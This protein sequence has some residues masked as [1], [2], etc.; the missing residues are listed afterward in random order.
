MYYLISCESY[1]KQDEEIKKIVKDNNYQI[2]NM[3]KNTLDEVI[4]ELS[5]ISF[6]NSIKYLVIT[7]APFFGVDKLKEE[8][9]KLLIDLLSKKSSDV[10]IFTTLNQVDKRKK[11]TKLIKDLGNLIE[12]PKF[13]KRYL[14]EEVVK[15]LNKYNY[16][17]DFNTSMYI[18]NN[19]FNNLDIIY[20]ELDKVIAYYNKPRTLTICDIRNIISR[21]IDDNN[22]HFVSL[23]IDKNLKEAFIS[24]KDL[25]KLKVEPTVLITLLARE[26]RLMYYVKNLKLNRIDLAKTLS[27]VDWQLDKLYNNSLKYTNKELLNNILNLSKLDIGIKKGL[28]DK[29]IALESFILDTI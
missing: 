5:F 12:Y 17:I 22:F 24:L 26:Y 7:N 23:V 16:K 28:Y 13:D 29:D 21:G 25:M 2:F 14:R 4:D 8:D 6:D 3:N 19:S 9:T 10:V 18:V 1:K 11:Q 15:Y 27:L 20:N